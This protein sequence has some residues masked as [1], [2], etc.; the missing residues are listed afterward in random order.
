[1]RPMHVKSLGLFMPGYRDAAA[2]LES[3]PDPS[4]TSPRDTL[5]ARARRGASLVS[6]MMADVTDQATD[7]AGFDPAT[8]RTVYASAYGEAQAA[9]ALLSMRHEGDG[10]LSPA[11]FSTSVH[12]AASGLVSISHGNRGFS[13]AIAGGPA[14]VALGLLEAATVFHEQPGPLVVTFADEPVP[15]RLAPALGFAPLA[16]A[17]GLTDDPAGAMASIADVRR[18]ARA[19][20][21]PPP[22]ASLERSPIAPALALLQALRGGAR[23]DLALERDALSPWSVRVLPPAAVA[24]AQLPPIG[25][26]LAHRPPMRL[27]EEASGWD[28]DHVECRVVVTDDSPFAEAGR[29]PALI[30]MEYM[31]QAIAVYAGLRGRERGEAPR[32][33]YLVGAR[34]VTLDVDDFC[35]GDVLRVTAWHVWGDDA[36]GSFRCEVERAGDVVA[37]ASLNV[38]QGDI[39]G[40]EGP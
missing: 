30:A 2:F 40:Q 6:R 20:S 23:I 5:P 37:K 18:M 38:A 22:P 24:S 32:I 15:E 14:T 31:A 3:R 39:H 21:G 1:M 17:I 35:V 8:V 4:A 16:V 25:G 33:G 19:A 29:V 34:D 36:L 12:N 26:L 28:G 27:L 10:R 11:R 9:L 7:A 13:T